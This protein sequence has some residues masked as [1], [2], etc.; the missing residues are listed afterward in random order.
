MDAV[1]LDSCQ[2][3]CIC[4][5]LPWA[6]TPLVVTSIFCALWT[7]SG[8]VGGDVPIIQQQQELTEHAP[9]VVESDAKNRQDESKEKGDIDIGAP[10]GDMDM[11]DPSEEMPKGQSEEYM[12]SPGE[13]EAKIQSDKV[14]FQWVAR[15]WS[16]TTRYKFGIQHEVPQVVTAPK[17]SLVG[18]AVVPS[19]LCDYLKQ[20]H[21]M[22]KAVKADDAAVPVHL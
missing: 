22:A 16:N 7:Q 12:S 9:G 15:G 10:A 20:E 21:D 18:R 13:E 8:G 11:D 17:T 1:L 3:H 2:E 4:G 6:I 19:E 5:L 14:L